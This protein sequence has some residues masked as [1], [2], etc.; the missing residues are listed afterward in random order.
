MEDETKRC[1]KC[2]EEKARAAFA[3][4]RR[5]RS[6][7]CAECKTCMAERWRRV[8]ADPALKAARRAKQRAATEKRRARDPVREWAGRVLRAIRCRASEQRV[9]FDLTVEWLVQAAPTFCPALGIRLNFDSRDRPRSE[10]ASVDRRN[11]GGPYTTDNV[12]IISYR[13]N[14]AKRDLTVDEI[15]R[16]ASFLQQSAPCP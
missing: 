5:N 14:S 12:V 3:I 11:A 8:A 7:L 4:N 9:A 6:G 13:A 16:L 2:G 15:V 10:T 1:T